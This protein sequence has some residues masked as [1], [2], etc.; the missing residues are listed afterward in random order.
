MLAVALLSFGALVW[1]VFLL[2]ERCFSW[3]VGALAAFVVATREPFL[4]QGVRAYVDI[5]FLALVVSAAVLEVAPRRGAA[6]R[7]W[8]C[9]PGRAA[10]PE[11]WLSAV[12]YW[13]YLAP[14]LDRPRAVRARRAGLAAPVLWA[15]SDLAITGEPFHSLTSTRDTAETLG[16][17]RGILKVPEILPRRLGEILRWVPLIGGTAGFFAALHVARRRAIGAGRARGAERDR[18]RADRASRACRCWAATCCCRRRCCAIFFA[19][20]ALGWLGLARGR[21]APRWLVGAAVLL[22]A[23]VGLDRL[24]PADRLD[25]LRDGIQL[26]GGIQDDLRELARDDRRERADRACGP[27]Y[28]PNHRPV[29]MLAWYL[30]RDP[31]EIVSAQLA[32]R[33]GRLRRPGQPQSS[34]TSSCSTRATR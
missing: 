32:A 11:A 12:A 29:P 5:P 30:D 28:V 17:P 19:F 33:V 15:L 1:A 9:W 23:F 27:I 14:G 31:D 24:P 26:R 2:G 4:S 18:V 34:G 20:A 7:C 3:P 10:A 22:V 21:P 16:R 25:R 8:C 13:L 6:R